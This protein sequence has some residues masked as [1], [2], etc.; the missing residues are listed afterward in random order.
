[1]KNNERSRFDVFNPQERAVLRVL[2]EM[3][4]NTV[5]TIAL[6]EEVRVAGYLLVLEKLEAECNQ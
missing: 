3:H 4:L 2:L 5:S 1:M 6:V